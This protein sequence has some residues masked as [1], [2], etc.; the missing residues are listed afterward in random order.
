MYV[1]SWGPMRPSSPPTGY[2][3]DSRGRITSHWYTAG[4][5]GGIVRSTNGRFR[6]SAIAMTVAIATKA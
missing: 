1:K 2:D 4:K 3:D 6:D 5:F